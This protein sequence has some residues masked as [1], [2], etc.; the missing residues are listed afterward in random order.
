MHSGR[1]ACKRG[2]RWQRRI[3]VLQLHENRAKD[4]QSAHHAPFYGSD[5]RV[6][7]TLEE[8]N[9]TRRDRGDVNLKVF[10]SHWRSAY[11]TKTNKKMFSRWIQNDTLADSSAPYNF[12][13]PS[14]QIC[15]CLRTN[16]IKAMSPCFSKRE[17]KAI[18]FANT[19]NRGPVCLF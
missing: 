6:Q 7:E 19:R 8:T 14:M 1:N 16:R 3:R 15:R 18:K 10:I 5:G 9:G 4:L 13:M 17:T 11:K 2:R 12:T